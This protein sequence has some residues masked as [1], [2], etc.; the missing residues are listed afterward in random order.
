M[1]LSS[2][3]SFLRVPLQH[4]FHQCNGLVAGV[5]DQGSEAGG[6]TLWE[7]EVH[8][9]GQVVALRPV[10][11]MWRETRENNKLVF[12][13]FVCIQDNVKC[14]ITNNFLPFEQCVIKQRHLLLVSYNK[15]A[16]TEGVTIIWDP[17]CDVSPSSAF[18]APDRSW[19]SRPPHCCQGT[20]V[21]VCRAP[22]WC[23][24]RPRCRWVS[25]RS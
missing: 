9:G 25:C 2:A 23:I 16:K 13:E 22:P 8:R 7:A 5:G 15:S 21:W 11:L 19:R 1:Y 3:W 6:D 18:P 10:W 24:P 4:V 17:C 14:I 20:G 12:S